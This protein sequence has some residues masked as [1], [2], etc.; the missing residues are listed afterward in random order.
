[1]DEM[2]IKFGGNFM[3]KIVSKLL[4]KVLKDKLGYNMDI[5]IKELDIN[6][7]DGDTKVSANVEVKFD[8]QEFKK[9]L[10]NSGLD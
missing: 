1:M 7:V 10:K 6:V 5:D 9:I 8:N 2:R 3:R 4:M